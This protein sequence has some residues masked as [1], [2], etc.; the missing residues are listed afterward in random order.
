MISEI[1]Q[2]YGGGNLISVD[3]QSR[4]PVYEQIK[5]QIITLIRLGVY[6]GGD[7][8]PSIRQISSDTSVNVNTVKKA[9]SELEING[10]IHTV[11]GTG[12]FV[13]EGA[14]DNPAV[15][16]KIT[17]DITNDFVTA[18]ALGVTREKIIEIL[19]DIYGGE[20]K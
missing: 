19:N 6:S 17:R 18:R 15:T 8:L 4:V 3:K 9:F 16:S 13:S 1:A 11:P 12:C 10:L 14:L 20:D 5:N 2:L 7:K